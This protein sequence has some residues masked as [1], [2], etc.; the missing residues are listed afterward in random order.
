MTFVSCLQRALR[1]TCTRRHFSSGKAIEQYLEPGSTELPQDFQFFPEFLTGPE[2]HVLLSSA[3]RKLDNMGSREARRKRKGKAVY[4]GESPTVSDLFLPDEYYEFEQVNFILLC[5][6]K[7]SKLRYQGHYDGVIKHFREAH[8]TSWPFN[9]SLEPAL[10]RL[11]SLLPQGDIQTHLL[12]LASNGEIFPH[13]DNVNASGS[14]IAAVSVGG[15]RVLKMEGPRN[16]EILL[17]SGSAYVHKYVEDIVQNSKLD[18]E[19]EHSEVPLPTF[20]HVQGKFQRASHT[21]RAAT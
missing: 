6:W 10:L 13:I 9:S 19:Q 14:W 11:R 7:I 3:L 12:H 15:E 5:H 2:Q 17:P 21:C 8:I 1:L 18:A 16:F 4:D 20:Y